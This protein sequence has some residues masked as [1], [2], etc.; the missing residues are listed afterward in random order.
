MRNNT[1]L[2]EDIARQL[3]SA[4]L[5]RIRYGCIEVAFFDDDGEVSCGSVGT[6]LGYLAADLSQD[7]DATDISGVVRVEVRTI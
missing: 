5:Y 7:G 2:I 3:N 6:M 1:A 4:E